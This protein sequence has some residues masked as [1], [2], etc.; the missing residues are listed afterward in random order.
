MDV[1]AKSA[2]QAQGLVADLAIHTLGW[3]A[4]QDLCAQVCAETWGTTVSV[5]REAQDGGQDA[6]FLTRKTGALYVQGAKLETLLTETVCEDST[7][8]RDAVV[9]PSSTSEHL[10]RRLL[11]APNVLDLTINVQRR[12]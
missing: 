12:R 8:I 3:K 4:F 6:V 1:M 10:V 11:E 5:Y 9:I 7:P 2:P